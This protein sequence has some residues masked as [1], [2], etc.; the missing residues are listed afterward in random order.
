MSLYDNPEYWRHRA[1]NA[2]ELARQASDPTIKEAMLDMVGRY[3]SLAERAQQRL[4]DEA[5]KVS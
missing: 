1:A 3:N 5:M 4:V 2:R